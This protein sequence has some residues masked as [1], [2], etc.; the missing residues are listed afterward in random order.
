MCVNLQ[1]DAKKCNIWQ[2]ILSVMTRIMR[3]IMKIDML[4]SRKRRMVNKVIVVMLMPLLDAVVLLV[5]FS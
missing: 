2:Q 1:P 5:V 3:R 4:L